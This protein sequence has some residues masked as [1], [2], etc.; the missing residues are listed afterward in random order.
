MADRLRALAR[1]ENGERDRNPGCESIADAGDRI[2]DG[3]YASAVCR[4]CAAREPLD[5]GF[6][7]LAAD[8]YGLLGLVLRCWH[9]GAI[10]EREV[11]SRRWF[12]AASKSR[13]CSLRRR[14]PLFHA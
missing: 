6:D 13:F 9:V 8:D 2:D 7:I 10:D 1:F 5:F 12:R 3:G 11:A 14:N 4:R